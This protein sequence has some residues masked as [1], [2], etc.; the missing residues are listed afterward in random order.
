[1]DATLQIMT[2]IFCGVVL[3]RTEGAINNMD[4]KTRSDIR[5]AFLL[6]AASALAAIFAIGLGYVPTWREPLMSGGVAVLM[7]A[8]RRIRLLST[9]TDRSAVQ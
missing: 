4:D 2:V 8:E 7:L 6:L 1:M 5:Y 3:L 9:P